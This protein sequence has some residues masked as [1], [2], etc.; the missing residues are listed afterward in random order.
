MTGYAFPTPV[1]IER[2]FAFYRAR[3]ERTKNP[4][5]VWVACHFALEHQQDI[6][7]WADAA[8]VDVGH[9]IALA[10]NQARAEH[11]PGTSAAWKKKALAAFG[12]QQHGDPFHQVE[13]DLDRYVLAARVRLRK[14]TGIKRRSAGVTEATRRTAQQFGLSFKTVQRAW[15]EFG[16]FIEAADISDLRRDIR[17]RSI[18]RRRQKNLR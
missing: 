10:L 1:A 15:F 16:A 12:F 17:H 11:R 13:A 2:A 4:L 9:Q 18:T 8:L 7:E 5:W 6:P 14:D 3:F